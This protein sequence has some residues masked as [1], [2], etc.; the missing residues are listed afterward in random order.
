MAVTIA[1]RQ[2]LHS[3]ESKPKYQKVFAFLIKFSEPHLMITITN[4]NQD[5]P[6]E[7]NVI[8]PYLE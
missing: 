4:N 1:D 5:P 7:T 6:M 2:R 8:Y 3:K